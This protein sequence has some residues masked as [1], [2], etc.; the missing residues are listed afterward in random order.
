MV[1]VLIHIKTSIKVLSGGKYGGLF[2]LAD[3]APATVSA[4]LLCSERRN[5][6][7]VTSS[8]MSIRSV[9]EIFG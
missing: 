5:Y 7:R 2:A 9:M 3:E 6:N 8:H 1:F 4:K